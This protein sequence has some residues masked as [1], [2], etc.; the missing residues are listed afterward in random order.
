MALEPP[1]VVTAWLALTPSSA[2]NGCLHFQP[3]SHL[4]QLPHVQ[5]LAEGNLLLKGQTIEVHRGVC[6]GLLVLLIAMQMQMQLQDCTAAGFFR[7]HLIV[8]S[9][10]AALI[11]CTPC[12]VHTLHRRHWKE[13]RGSTSCCSPARRR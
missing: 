8:C 12:A 1:D 13:S 6:R 9:P 10:C 5:T 11:V 2:A 4:Q 7:R 3:A